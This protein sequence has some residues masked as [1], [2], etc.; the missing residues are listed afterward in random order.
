M[1]KMQEILDSI[2][3]QGITDSRDVYYLLTKYQ[4]IKKV[5]KP[6]TQVDPPSD[7]LY[8]LELEVH[9][10]GQSEF[11]PFIKPK[12]EHKT[13]VESVQFPKF[14]KRIRI[15]LSI[16][17][18]D[19]QYSPY[20]NAFIESIS[21]VN[22]PY[23]IYSD[24]PNTI[25]SDSR[26]YAEVANDLVCSIRK[27]LR[28]KEFAALLRH[29]KENS[30]R[31]F[32][33]SL[34]YVNNLFDQHSRLIHVRID[35]AL[36]RTENNT[37]PDTTTDALSVLLRY[38][39]ILLNRIKRKSKPFHYLVGYIAHL[40]YGPEKGH[41]LH[42]SFFF[43]GHKRKNHK[44]IAYQIS[45]LWLK[46]TNDT[47]L[48]YSTN[49]VS[50]APICNA[51]GEIKREDKE[52]RKCLLYVLWYMTKLDQYVTYKHKDR[53]RLFYRGEIA[54]KKKRNKISKLS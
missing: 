19:I 26:L 3:D 28:S 36:K 14:L 24:D 17:Q 42:L 11:L 40:E 8:A 39:K 21:M 15:W 20:I 44:N 10:I 45:N 5:K 6:I 31:S 30:Y 52:K 7:Q 32:K 18:P 46:I 27:R 50:R 37:A 35:L 48:T 23:P 41:H 54:N 29:R 43:N 34:Q 38:W 33:S 49:L 12:G 53:Q 13:F 1:T 25:L 51:L 16:L 22:F 47:G 2:G 9:K 4:E